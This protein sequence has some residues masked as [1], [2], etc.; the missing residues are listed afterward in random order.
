MDPTLEKTVRDIPA[1][2]VDEI[3]LV[4]DAS[5]DGTVAMD[6]G[7]RRQVR[8]AMTGDLVG[9]GPRVD[10]PMKKGDTRVLRCK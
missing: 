1:G 3:I 7:K 10:L 5:Q 4:D 2:C 9:S 8:D 6:V